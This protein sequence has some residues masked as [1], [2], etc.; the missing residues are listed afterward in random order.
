MNNTLGL[1]IAFVLGC[2]VANSNNNRPANTAGNGS[3]GEPGPGGSM[4]NDTAAPNTSVQLP[5]LSLGQQCNGG[6]CGITR[7]PTGRRVFRQ[8]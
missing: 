7:Q 2:M 6:G 4:P 8:F 5:L 1:L 3:L